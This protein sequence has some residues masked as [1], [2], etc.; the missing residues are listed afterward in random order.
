MHEAKEDG[1]ETDDT[2]EAL[3]RLQ[4]DIHLEEINREM[5][6]NRTRKG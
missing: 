2:E 4:R 1:N 6:L 5:L 3:D